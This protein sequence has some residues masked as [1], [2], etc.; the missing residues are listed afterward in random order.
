MNPL[1]RIDFSISDSLKIVRKS[2]LIYDTIIECH[3]RVF[4]MSVRC[5]IVV[6]HSDAVAEEADVV[7]RLDHGKIVESL[8]S[9][10]LSKSRKS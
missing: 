2:V 10:M 1:F 4:Y 5:V 8:K 7:L 6:T 3:S 9:G